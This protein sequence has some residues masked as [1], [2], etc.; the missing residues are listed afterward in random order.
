M[1]I[2]SIPFILK[3]KSFYTY[4][5][6]RI[7]TSPFNV[8]FYELYFHNIVSYWSIRSIVLLM[9]MICG[10]NFSLISESEIVIF[11]PIDHL[12]LERQRIHT[13]FLKMAV[14][15]A[16]WCAN[17]YTALHDHTFSLNLACGSA[18]PAYLFLFHISYLNWF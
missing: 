15:N 16:Y 17:T 1:F 5:S 11:L 8:Y 18:L 4:N 9:K 12:T 2:L 3:S 10:S 14:K 6:L 7:T 13:W